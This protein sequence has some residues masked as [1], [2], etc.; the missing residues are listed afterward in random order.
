MLSQSH[1]YVFHNCEEDVGIGVDYG[2]T[3][4]AIIFVMGF[5]YIE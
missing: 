3:Q 5:S 2:K 4:G 1:S